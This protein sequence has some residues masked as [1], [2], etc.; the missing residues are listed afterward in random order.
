MAFLDPRPPATG[1]P[2]EMFSRAELAANQGHPGLLRREANQAA[3]RC[4]SCGWLPDDERQRARQRQDLTVT[5]LYPDP[6]RPEE[7]LTRQH[8]ERCQPIRRPVGLDCVICGDGPLL[9]GDS[10][11]AAE[12]GE[13]SDT[14]RRWLN[15]EG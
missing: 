8:C 13:L 12:S 15:R 10:T 4:P 3:T 7:L 11:V 14:V 6:D 2:G 1:R 9:Y 5:W